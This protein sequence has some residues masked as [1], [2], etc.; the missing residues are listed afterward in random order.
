M[1]DNTAEHCINENFKLFY[2]SDK[3]TCEIGCNTSFGDRGSSVWFCCAL[4]SENK[5][6]WGSTTNSL[7]SN[8][9]SLVLPSPLMRTNSSSSLAH[10]GGILKKERSK[11]DLYNK[12]LVDW[13]SIIFCKETLQIKLYRS[14][15]VNL[16]LST[17]IINKLTPRQIMARL[18]EG[19][20]QLRADP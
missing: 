11:V 14:T 13:Y 20:I 8:T 5:K 17:S 15:F 7:T 1:S 6:D 19:E 2:R 10:G 16:F 9:T 3:K 18:T 4:I 12:F